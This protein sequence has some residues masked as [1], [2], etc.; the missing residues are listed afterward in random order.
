[1]D[2]MLIVGSPPKLRSPPENQTAERR[3]T[4]FIDKKHLP[5]E[6]S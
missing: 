1:M 4:I 5:D 6:A 2:F 3:R